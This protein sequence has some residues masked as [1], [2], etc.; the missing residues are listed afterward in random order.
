M[1]LPAFLQTKSALPR[2]LAGRYHRSRIAQRSQPSLLRT[3][4][5]LLF[6][7]AASDSRW[8]PILWLGQSNQIVCEASAALLYCQ[9]RNINRALPPCDGH[10]GTLVEES[11]RPQLQSISRAEHS[12]DSPAAVFPAFLS[13]GCKLLHKDSQSCFPNAD[14][15]NT[16]SV[17]YRCSRESFS[18]LH[19]FRHSRL[20][21]SSP[22]TPTY[23][24]SG[25]T[26]RFWHKTSA[27]LL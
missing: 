8:T 14:S 1:H 27:I 17:R 5:T 20:T 2:D 12:L 23:A 22:N 24:C 11:L 3:L 25:L 18:P 13:L 10:V 21:R 15:P 19:V 6:S 9:A 7:T 26:M 16:S 4:P